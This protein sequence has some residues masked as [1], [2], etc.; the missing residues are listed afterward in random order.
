MDAR[1]RLAERAPPYARRVRRAD[2]CSLP[3]A[4]RRRRAPPGPSSTAPSPTPACWPLA[5]LG[6]ALVL[7][8]L[9]GR[10]A[11]LGVPGRPRL[12]RRLLLPAHR[13]G[14][15]SSS[16]R[17]RGRRSRCSM[18]LWCGLGAVPDRLGVP[19][20]AAR[21]PERARHGSLL[22]PRS[23]RACGSRARASPASGRTA[24][25]RGAGSAFSQSDSPLARC[26][27]GSGSRASGS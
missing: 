17:S 13:V 19:L 7:V 11:R 15:A 20:A 27:P 4:A 2:A 12:R 18:A 6:I 3:W 9:H 14:R 22:L 23:S 25:S 16:A 24:A 1:A 10:T 21:L 5:F 26:S 8:A